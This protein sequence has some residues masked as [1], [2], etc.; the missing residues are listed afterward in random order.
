MNRF[1]I[2]FRV[3]GTLFDTLVER[4]K[5]DGLSLIFDLSSEGGLLK[6]TDKIIWDIELVGINEVP[7][8]IIAQLPTKMTSDSCIKVTKE[9]NKNANVI[10]TDGNFESMAISHVGNY[11]SFAMVRR[12]C[13]NLERAVFSAKSNS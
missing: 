6:L 12:A 7:K 4:Y 5:P 2:S 8:T 3:A 9:I 10:V 11:V 1:I 13:E